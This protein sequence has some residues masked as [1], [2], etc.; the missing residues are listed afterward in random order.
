MCRVTTGH[1]NRVVFLYKYIM[2][3]LNRRYYYKKKERKERYYV[4][5]GNYIGG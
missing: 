2:K 4:I 3:K 5:L 1:N